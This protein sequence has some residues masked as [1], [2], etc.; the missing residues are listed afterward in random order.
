MSGP[1]LPEGSVEVARITIV[2]TFDD[3][4]EGGAAIYTSYSENLPLVDA[5][6]MLA[7]SQAMTVRDY[8]G[9]D[10]D[11]DGDSQ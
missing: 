11:D 5:L 6:G 3:D 8:L 1:E 2:K 9:D 10:D 4:A 7:F